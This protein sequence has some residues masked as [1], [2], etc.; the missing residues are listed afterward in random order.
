MLFRSALI[1]DRRDVT[2]KFT[3]LQATAGLASFLG[4]STIDI[5]G[6]NLAVAI[7]KGLNNNFPAIPGASANTVYRLLIADQTLGNVTFGF[8]S[9]TAVANILGADSDISVAGKVQTAIEGL[10]G[11]GAGNV[12]VTGTRTGGFT[13]E[14]INSL[15]KTNLTGLTVSTNATLAG[16]VAA[17]QTAAS[18]TGVS[19]VQSLT[20]TRQTQIGRAHV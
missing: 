10:T 2:R 11:I 18:V 4:N 20:L 6:T 17:N 12:V 8:G 9:S 7:N 14:F 13:V 5:T 3:S 19:A 15:A 16:S 1:T